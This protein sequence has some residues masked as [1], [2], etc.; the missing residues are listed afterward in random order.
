MKHQ[1]GTWYMYIGGARGLASWA[2]VL[3]TVFYLVSFIPEVRKAYYQ[4][5]IVYERKVHY[6]QKVCMDK[7][8]RADLEGETNCDLNHVYIQQGPLERAFFH[9]FSRFCGENSCLWLMG[10]TLSTALCV[11]V[12][13]FLLALYNVR[14]TVQRMRELREQLPLLREMM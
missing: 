6:L 13:L 2:L 4:E 10:R 8:L 11:V 7:M 12:S 14:G 5:V 1:E 3:L 9:V